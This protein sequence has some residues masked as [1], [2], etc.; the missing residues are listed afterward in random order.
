MDKEFIKP[1]SYNICEYKKNK[2]I[3][4]CDKSVSNYIKIILDNTLHISFDKFIINFINNLNDI[5]AN[6]PKDVNIIYAYIDTS[7]DDYLEKSNYWLYTYI[8]NYLKEISSTIHINIITNLQTKQL[9]DNDIIL[10]IDD[11]IYSGNQLS[12]MINDMNNIYKLKLYFH[13]LVPYG[14]MYG[15]N[16]I[17]ETFNNN[18]SLSTTC[19]L[20]LYKYMYKIHKT[21]NDYLTIDE[22][23][24]LEDIY[25]NYCSFNNVILI[26][27]DHKLADYYSIPTIIYSGVIANRKNREIFT[28]IKNLNRIDN[29][30]LH[31]KKEFAS[32]LDYLEF[33]NHTEGFRNLNL[34]NP[35]CLIPPYKKDKYN[36]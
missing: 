27:F 33:I 3:E 2:F 13:L 1:L 30:Y 24:I 7:D 14:S 22:I 28:N 6:L 15:I 16:H 8:N 23:K 32:K 12:H 26:Y 21:I 34:L 10:I 31:K 20:Y 17:I 36:Q 35:I 18:K 11:C 25:G 19:N 4:L 5:I 9:K 29:N